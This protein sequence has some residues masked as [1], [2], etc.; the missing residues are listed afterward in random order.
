M[1]HRAV[2]ERADVYHFHDPELI[3][4]GLL[5]RLLGKRVI[6][7][8]H[9]DLPRQVMT[10]HWIPRSLR[11][12][13][14][15]AVEWVERMATVFFDGVVVATPIIYNRFADRRAVTVQNFPDL[16]EFPDCLLKPYS[17]RTRGAVYVGG[18][19]RTRGIQ[20]MLE[21]CQYLQDVP[22][23]RLGLAGSFD[24]P[25]L[26]DE[27]EQLPGWS[28]VEFF[29]WQERGGVRD[30]L[31]DARVGLVV[32]HP[33]ANYVQSYPVK[34]FEYMAAGVPVVASD[35]PIWRDILERT[36]CGLVVDPAD[37]QAI[38][39]AIRDLLDSPSMAEEMG[40]N[41]REAILKHYNWEREKR[42]L[43]ELYREAVGDAVV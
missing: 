26:R 25:E 19:S 15:C 39:C 16:L 42:A 7:D 23:F 29:G 13:V 17:E 20:E 2:S 10:K 43:V 38:G 40:R 37:P 34:L 3:P 5:L 31:V 9:E 41:G 28:R 33:T 14:S 6:Y 21:S 36:R 8:V 4:L 11:G 27:M 35:F 32:L 24:P 18:I 1:L 22:S 30:L 12:V